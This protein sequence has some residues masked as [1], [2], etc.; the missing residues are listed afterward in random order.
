YLLALLAAVVTLVMV[1]RWSWH[2][3]AHWSSAVVKDSDPTDPPLHSRTC[4]GP[5]VWGM[6][7]SL[8]ANGA[9]YLSLLFGWFYL[10]T[11]APRWSA[12]AEGPL[13]LWGLLASGLLLSGAVLLNNYLVA[14]LRKRDDLHLERNLWLVVG[15]GI[16]HFVLLL[17]VLSSAP[18]NPGALAHDAV[19]T[20]VLYYLL[21]HSGL[22]ILFSGLKAL[23]VRCGYVG[24]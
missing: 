22:A 3:C 14:R 17:R 1:L 16:A 9:L 13:S 19:L 11:A 24:R 2:N 18:L 7:V 20:F 23:R 5:G 6:V 15:L 4:N 21:L 8:F 12:P 10:W